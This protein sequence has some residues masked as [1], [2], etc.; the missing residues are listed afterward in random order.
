MK[1]Y[2]FLR[3]IAFILVIITS[4]NAQQL[5]N[6]WGTYHEDLEKIRTELKQERQDSLAIKQLIRDAELAMGLDTFSVVNNSP[7]PPSGNKKDYY[8]WAPYL[9]PNPDTKDGLPYISKDGKTNPETDMKSDKPQLRRMTMAVQT[10]GLAYYYT[11]DKR[12]AHKAATLLK[13]WFLDPETGMN[14]NLNYGQAIPGEVEGRSSGIIDTRWY[15]ILMNSIK[16]LNNSDALTS[17]DMLHLKSWFE[18]YLNW[19]LTNKMGQE[20]AQS[21]NNHGTWY[22]AQIASFALFTDNIQLTKNV[23]NNSRK[24]FDSQLDSLGRQIHELRR[25]KSFDYSLYNIHALINLAMIAEQVDIDLW[26]YNAESKK[27]LYNAIR[28]MADH[29]YSDKDWPYEQI[30]EKVITLN[31]E[32]GLDFSVYYPYDLYTALRVGYKVYQDPLFMKSME[33]ISVDKVK[34]HRS[35]LLIYL[36]QR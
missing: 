25:T 23:V 28:Y 14:P 7:I 12:Y 20:E 5:S 19:L 33:K 8:S 16:L 15:I 13:G 32:N 26:H 3:I 4:G 18:D 6:A 24:F 11:Q 10:L 1:S 9:W 35:N 31:Y 34:A 36:E 27:N 22:A 30:S 29:Y 2:C 21:E 17:M